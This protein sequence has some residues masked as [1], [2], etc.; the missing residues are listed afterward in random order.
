MHKHH[1]FQMLCSQ[2]HEESQQKF[3]TTTTSPL[4]I[5]PNFNDSNRKGCQTGFPSLHVC[6][7]VQK[8]ESQVKRWVVSCLGICQHHVVVQNGTEFALAFCHVIHYITS[9]GLG[10]MKLERG[11]GAH[12]VI[13][14]SKLHWTEPSPVKCILSI[15]WDTNLAIAMEFQCSWSWAT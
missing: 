3:A 15:F 4:A 9:F 5:L 2:R 8:H 13:Q 11:F 6:F 1:E 10:V 12:T 14:F 7:D